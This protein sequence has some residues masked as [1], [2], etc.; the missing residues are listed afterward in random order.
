MQSNE[1]QLRI[2]HNKFIRTD[3]FHRINSIE[4]SPIDFQLERMTKKAQGYQQSLGKMSLGAATT[5]PHNVIG[6]GE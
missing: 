1:M 3:K 4:Q 2:K 5:T 6:H